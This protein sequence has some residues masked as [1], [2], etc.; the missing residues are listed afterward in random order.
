[1]QLVSTWLY[2]YLFKEWCYLLR[3]L[4]KFQEYTVIWFVVFTIGSQIKIM[5]QW[6][7]IFLKLIL[8]LISCQIS[9]LYF[10]EGR[11]CF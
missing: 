6:L 3:K 11:F 8:N 2:N 5:I 10:K 4:Y 7:T 9:R 1:M